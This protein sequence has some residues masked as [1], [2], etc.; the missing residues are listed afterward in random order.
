MQGRPSV[1]ALRA[2]MARFYAQLPFDFAPRYRAMFAELLA[3]GAP[4]A[5][6]CS[7]GKDRTG[8]AA[9]LT[10]LALGVPRETVLEDFLLS[11]AAAEAQGAARVQA[12]AADPAAQAMLA[13]LPEELRRVLAGVEREWLENA[14]QAIEAREGSL[15]AYFERQLGLGPRQIAAL[16]ARYLE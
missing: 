4:L 2:G 6:N 11:N 3:G 12:A 13:R 16:R 15:E 5:F 8:V 1:Q 9:A 10:L 14:L 7:A